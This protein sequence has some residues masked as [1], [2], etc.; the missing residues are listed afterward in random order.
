MKV[1]LIGENPND[2]DAIAVLLRKRHNHNYVSVLKRRK[3]GQLDN[4]KFTK[5]LKTE[6]NADTYDVLIFVR[7]LDGFETEED[8]VKKRQDWFDINSTS[9]GGKSLF[10]LNVHELEAIFFADVDSLNKLFGLKLKF[11]N[12]MFISNPKEELKKISSAKYNENR[13][14]EYMV[15]LDY[16]AVLS[17]YKPLKEIHNYFKE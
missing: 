16:N 7:D 11:K 4:D 17:N 2:T 9:F 15:S 6:L 8:K 3:G 12:P 10:L 14:A 1:G 13:A 5:L